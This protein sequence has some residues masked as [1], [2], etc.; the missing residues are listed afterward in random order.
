MA[1]LLIVEDEPKILEAQVKFLEREGHTCDTATNGREAFDLVLKNDYD[2]DAIVCDLLMP[3]MDGQDFLEEI[4]PHLETRTPVIITSG[5]AY[6]LEALGE[7]RRGAFSVLQKPY[8]MQELADTVGRAL[9]WRRV[10]IENRK[11]KDT[12]DRLSQDRDI[13][14][15]RNRKLYERSRQDPLTRLPN[16]IQM[17]RTLK[18]FHANA[19]RYESE[20]AIAF[21][22]LDKFARYNKRYSHRA[23][24]AVLTAAA[25]VLEDGCRAGDTLYRWGGD[26]FVMILS[27]QSEEGAAIAVDRLRQRLESQPIRLG[28]EGAEEHVTFSAGVSAI[29]DG[30][31]TLQAVMD[32]ANQRMKEAKA[33]GGNC[34]RPGPRHEAREAR[35]AG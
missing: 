7:M 24:D 29:R 10:L 15:A 35:A 16:R 13:L 20:F 14:M 30:S 8:E 6:M 3:Y 21:C 32:E 33:A 18:V 12:V 26:E 23:G 25:K 1:H 22:D 27:G 28:A 9:K 34:V 4:Y 5:V 17:D 31:R 11:L 19:G 2:Y